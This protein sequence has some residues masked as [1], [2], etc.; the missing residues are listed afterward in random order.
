MQG[1]PIGVLWGSRTLRDDSGNIVFDENGFPDQDELEGVIGDPNP[2]W[3][4]SASTT[5]SYKNFSISMLFETYQ[6]ADIYAGTKSVLYDLGT[7]GASAEE[8]TAGQ[9]LL[10]FTGNVILAGTTFRG[11]I[12]NFGAGP[13]ALT[14]TWYNADGG[15]FGSGNDELYIEDGSWTRLREL[16]LSY[17]INS[18]GLK[19]NTGIGSAEISLTGRNLFIWTPFEGNDPD[20]NLQ[21]VS[22]ARGIDYFN[23]PST[24]SYI[25]SL[26][27]T[28]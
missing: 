23:N 2:D 5:I 10:D 26:S 22:V 21:G 3:Q 24:K 17:R 11:K 13:V 18:E 19:K 16:T 15:F 6:G 27:V 12:H 9:N 1:Y 7:W 14:E 25:A 28:F 20:T 8:A 4:G